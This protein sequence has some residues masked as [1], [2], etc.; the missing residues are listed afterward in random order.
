MD[1]SKIVTIR[2]FDSEVEASIVKGLL[3]AAGINSSLI[4]ETMQSVLPL[5]SL[6]QIELCVAAKDEKRALELISAKFDKEDFERETRTEPKPR[7]KCS[8]KK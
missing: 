1:E 3:D 2:K 8:C 7:S 4:H 5:Q 6:T